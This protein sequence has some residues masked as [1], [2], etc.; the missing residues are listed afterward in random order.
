[1]QYDE[2][3]ADVLII[4]KRKG[5]KEVWHESVTDGF[6]EHLALHVLAQNVL[7]VPLIS[8]FNIK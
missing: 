2:Y 6:Q 1:M 4:M 5:C 3:M 7:F 8:F